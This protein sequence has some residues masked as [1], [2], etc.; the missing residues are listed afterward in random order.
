MNVGD[1][2][3]CFANASPPVTSIFLSVNGFQISKGSEYQIYSIQSVG[4]YNCVAFNYIYGFTESAC[5]GTAFVNGTAT[6]L[7]E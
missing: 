4:D 1:N 2:L 6:M 5:N 7:C 3:T